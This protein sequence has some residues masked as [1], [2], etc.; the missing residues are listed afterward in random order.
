MLQHANAKKVE[1]LPHSP[2]Q[3]FI[4]QT[5]TFNGGQVW[6]NFSLSRIIPA[7]DITTFSMPLEAYTII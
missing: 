2:P 6:Q 3:V 5:S 7:F 4:H 1:K